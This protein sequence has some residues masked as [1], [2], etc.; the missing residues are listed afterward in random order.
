MIRLSTNYY[1]RT[2]EKEVAD[3]YFP[4]EYASVA[5]PEGSTLWRIDG[6]KIYIP[7]Q[8]ELVYYEIHL[9]KRS[10]GWK[11]LFQ[12]HKSAYSSVKSMLYFL[13][14]H[15]DDFR[16]YDEYDKIMSINELKEEL[17]DW[18]VGVAHVKYYYR[19]ELRGTRI[20]YSVDI[21]PDNYIGET[22]ETPFSHIEYQN[23]INRN[24]TFKIP[25]YEHMDYTMD[26]QGYEFCDREF[27]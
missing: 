3:K 26:K 21:A 23:F 7:S 22:I 16:I 15:R 1:I 4:D 27:S 12:T 17:V 2:Y 14:R 19:E 11:P 13:T 8:D 9:G 25:L 18:A 5:L 6:K 10:A 24:A 20:R